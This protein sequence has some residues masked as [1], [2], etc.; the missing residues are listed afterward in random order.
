MFDQLLHDPK[1]DGAD[2]G[3]NQTGIE[4]MEGTAHGSD[5]NLGGITII[6]E[7]GADLLDSIH[8]VMTYIV[9]ATDKR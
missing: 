5:D 6:I 8:A 9:E 2:I 3:P 4:N 1:R 7:N